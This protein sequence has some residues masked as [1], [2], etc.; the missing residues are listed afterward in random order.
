MIVAR[1]INQSS[2]TSVREYATTSRL[3]K[4]ACSCCSLVRIPK[5]V[6]AASSTKLTANSCC[7]WSSLNMA[8]S[9]LHSRSWMRK[10]NVI[11]CLIS[12]KRRSLQEKWTKQTKTMTENSA[13]KKKKT[14]KIIMTNDSRSLKRHFCDLKLC[15]TFKK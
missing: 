2:S 15:Q 3:W 11:N 5:T 8:S 7:L 14:Y 10:T 13:K 9:T 6:A 1:K 4:D 12:L